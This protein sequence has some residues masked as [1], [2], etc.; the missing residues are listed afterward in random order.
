MFKRVKTF[1]LNHFGFYHHSEVLKEK[2]ESY[3]AGMLDA[4]QHMSS[5]SIPTKPQDFKPFFIHFNRGRRKT[6]SGA[7]KQRPVGFT[8]Y[9]QPG[10]DHRTVFVSI[11]HCSYKDEFCKKE[12]RKQALQCL[13]WNKVNIRDVP[14]VLT[15]ARNKCTGWKTDRVCYYYAYRYML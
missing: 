2:V 8:A 9:V 14:D 3:A 11:T 10:D 4:Q 7:D 5:D 15:E 1:L 12:G 6:D 13:T